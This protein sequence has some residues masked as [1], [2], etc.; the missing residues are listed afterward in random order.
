MQIGGVG[1]V[2]CYGSD[3]F[4]HVIDAC[5][6]RNVDRGEGTSPFESLLARGGA[7]KPP[8]SVCH[9]VHMCIAATTTAA[10][11]LTAVAGADPAATSSIVV[12]RPPVCRSG[13]LQ[14]GALARVA[15]LIVHFA[16]FAAAY[17]CRV[18]IIRAIR[19]RHV[20]LVHAT[21]VLWR[22]RFSSNR[23]SIRAEVKS[24]VAEW[25]VSVW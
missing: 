22:V 15:A 25:R 10:A 24:Y 6:G 11:L 8:V 13:L 18:R 14:H 1:Y 9:A 17:Y 20:R 3:R 19:E 16:D 2:D 5:Y 23:P 12:R 4:V 7:R 21:K